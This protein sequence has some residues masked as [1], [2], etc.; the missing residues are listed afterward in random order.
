MR[1]TN[2]AGLPEP[3]YQW[4]LKTAA[5]Y[6]KDGADISVSEL[7]DSPRI[8][9]LKKRLNDQI[10]IEAE[11][12][13][14]VTVGNCVHDGIEKA[15][16]VGTPERRLSIAILG[17]ILSGG[18]DYHHDGV[19]SDYKTANKWKTVLSDDGRVESWENQLNVYAHILRK[20]G[21]EVNELFIWVYFK[22][23]NRGEY[24]RY[25]EK[26][27]I[28][29]PYLSS[30]YPEKEWLKIPI[31]LWSEEEAEDYIN[32]RMEMH[33][34]AEKV[35]PECSREDRWRGTLRCDRYCDVSFGCEQYKQIKERK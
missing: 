16:K 4:V 13:L 1:I 12:L 8:R 5:E 2:K 23:W 33:Q 7:I 19:L 11:N 30:G 6:T 10:E 24:S 25:M 32:V 34:N 15:T 14:S 21:I 22:D 28:F 20:H 27:Q 29:R 3:V 31:T 18:M 17:W 35:L 9:V 26:G